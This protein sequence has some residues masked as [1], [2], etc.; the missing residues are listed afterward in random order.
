VCRY[1]PEHRSLVIDHIMGT[2]LKLPPT[3]RTLRRYMFPDDDPHAIQVLT[4]MLMKCIQAS[5]TFQDRLPAEED[6]D[7]VGLYK[8]NAVDTH[9]LKAPRFK[10]GGRTRCMQ[11]LTHSLKAPGFNTCTATPRRSSTRRL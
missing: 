7:A 1:N 5:V 11:L 8:L 10:P 3:G 6:P 2:L 4:A 9:S